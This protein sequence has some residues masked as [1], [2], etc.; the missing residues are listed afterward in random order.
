MPRRIIRMTAREVEGLL[1]G[2]G[3][4]PV[5]QR[6]SRRKW[7]QARRGLQVIVPQHHG[8][9]L[10]LGTSRNILVNAEIPESE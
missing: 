10:P 8:R 5:C 3:F 9:Q 2:H 1:R 7:R 6:G 4:Q